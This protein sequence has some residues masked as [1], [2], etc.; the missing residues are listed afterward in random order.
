MPWQLCQAGDHSSAEL[1]NPL[2]I[3]LLIIHIIHVLSGC[4]CWYEWWG[5]VVRVWLSGGI[6]GDV[7][8]SVEQFCSVWLCMHTM[9]GS[10][11]QR[12]CLWGLCGASEGLLCCYVHVGVSALNLLGGLRGC[13]GSSVVSMWTFKCTWHLA[14]TYW[15][16]WLR[17]TP[18]YTLCKHTMANSF[19]LFCWASDA[20]SADKNCLAIWAHCKNGKILTKCQVCNKEIFSD[21]G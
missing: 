11:L 5:W 2:S 12:V 18:A 16:S 21:F 9:L 14:A 15:G 3:F 8:R 1:L 10:F 7:S 4:V 6:C 19:A 20:E 13:L 17:L